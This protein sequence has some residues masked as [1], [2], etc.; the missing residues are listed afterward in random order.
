MGMASESINV[1]L[2]RIEPPEILVGDEHDD[3]F[4]CFIHDHIQEY[5]MRLLESEELKQYYMQLGE[6]RIDWYSDINDGHCEG[7]LVYIMDTVRESEFDESRIEPKGRVLSETG[8]PVH[9]WLQYETESGECYHFDAEAPWGVK[10][11]KSLPPIRRNLPFILLKTEEK[12]ID[13]R[14]DPNNTV[15]GFYRFRNEKQSD[16]LTVNVSE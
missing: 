14:K 13:P 8:D 5:A 6:G 11:W 2:S 12:H 15:S 1:E 3:E 16:G 9:Y 4:A 7:V 10:D